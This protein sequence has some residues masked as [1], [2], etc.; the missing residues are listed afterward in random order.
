MI[1]PVLVTVTAAPPPDVDAEIS[2]DQT[3]VVDA[4]PKEVDADASVGIR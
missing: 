2:L 3:L 1:V 4:T